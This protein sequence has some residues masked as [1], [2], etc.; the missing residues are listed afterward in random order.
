MNSSF[1]HL[2]GYYNEQGNWV[3]TKFCFMSCGESC[4]CMPPGGIW[5]IGTENMYEEDGDWKS[6]SDGGPT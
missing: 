6:R 5:H 4:D 3:R 1:F 2:G